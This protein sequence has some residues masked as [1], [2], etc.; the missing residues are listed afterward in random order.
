[1]DKYILISQLGKGNFGSISKI[2][3]KSDNKI[4]IWKELS[5]SH[6]S[7]K[8]KQQIVTEVNILRDLNHPNIVSYIDRIIDKK[9]LKLYIVMEYCEKGDLNLLIKSLKKSKTHLQETQIWTILTQLILALQHC[10]K[11]RILHRDIKASN[12]F[13]DKNNTIKLGDFGLSKVLNPESVFAYSKVGTPYYMSPEQIDE[14]QYN[15]K[16]D[17]WSLGCLIYEL[18]ELHPPFEAKTHVQLAMKI[19]SGKLERINEMYSDELWRVIKRMLNVDFEKRADID[20]VMNYPVVFMRVKEK[21]FLEWERKLK[22]K[23]EELHEKE[24]MLIQQQQQ[25]HLYGNSNASSN[26]SNYTSYK[27]TNSNTAEGSDSNYKYSNENAQT[28]N[29]KHNNNN[30]LYIKDSNSFDY[31]TTT[32]HNQK[33]NVLNSKAP[34]STRLLNVKIKDKIS[35]LINNNTNNNNICNTHSNNNMIM[36]TI[37]SCEFISPSIGNNVYDYRNILNSLNP[38]KKLPSEMYGSAE[39]QSIPKTTTHSTSKHKRTN[40]LTKRAS[41]P[42]LTMNINTYYNNN[43]NNNNKHNYNNYGNYTT[44]NQQRHT[45]NHN[46]QQIAMNN[47]CIPMMRNNSS[48][49]LHIQRSKYTNN[50]N[51]NNI[52]TP[53][54]RIFKR[55]K[56]NN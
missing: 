54:S 9:N 24:L 32:S 52:S 47:N 7:Q 48:N 38:S 4:L 16:S 3:R 51:N 46:Y 22:L 25:L 33:A 5:Y 50:N 17:M 6:L 20:E 8:E 39:I 26:N 41:T 28:N 40:S 30:N 23:E 55:K 45:I 36:N 49:Q 27:S 18:C 53:T 43:P 15:D 37:K 31:V 44:I 14:K 35:T 13:Q 56:T 19:K 34:Y 12:V 29:S 1:M 10:H 2:K 21:Q 11:K 42:N